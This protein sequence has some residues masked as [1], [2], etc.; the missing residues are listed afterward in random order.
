MEVCDFCG[1]SVDEASAR[2]NLAG[3]SVVLCMD[4]SV[5]IVNDWEKRKSAVSDRIFDRIRESFAE[6]AKEGPS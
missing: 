3:V 5:P 2:G 6:S 4:C 1:N